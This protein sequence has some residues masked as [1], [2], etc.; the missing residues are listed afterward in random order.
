[1][2][3]T[4]PL[5]ILT[6][7][8][9]IFSTWW[10]FSSM[11]RL[12]LIDLNILSWNGHQSV[13]SATQRFFKPW[14]RLREPCSLALMAANW[15]QPGSLPRSQHDET[16]GRKPH[17]TGRFGSFV[18]LIIK[19]HL[20]PIIGTKTLEQWHVEPSTGSQDSLYS[21]KAEYVLPADSHTYTDLCTGALS[22]GPHG[23]SYNCWVVR[24][25]MTLVSSQLAFSH[26]NF[27]YPT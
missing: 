2:T 14:D 12:Y 24:N 17:S 23:N 10:G 18:F 1:M 9:S 19:V 26:F 15:R 8:R 22:L 27:H 20:W 6:A 13:P 7:V 4:K 3:Q 25:R 5:L 16:L 11:P 21:M